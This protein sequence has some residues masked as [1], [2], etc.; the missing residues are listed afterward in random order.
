MA[1]IKN[2]PDTQIH[3]VP[4]YS[5]NM[6]HIPEPEGRFW[7]AI[8]PRLFGHRTA[9]ALIVLIHVVASFFL[10]RLEFNNSPSL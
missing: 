3:E 7:K 1:S 9:I 10:L 2:A 5:P 6:V 8:E 4:Q